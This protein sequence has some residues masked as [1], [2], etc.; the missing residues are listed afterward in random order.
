MKYYK[1]RTELLM[2]SNA[3]KVMH[4]VCIKSIRQI[5]IHAIFLAYTCLSYFTEI[6]NETLINKIGLEP[7][8][9]KNKVNYVFVRE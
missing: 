7:K 5:S 2:Q 4:S 6:T 1:N 3:Y 9:N 8:F